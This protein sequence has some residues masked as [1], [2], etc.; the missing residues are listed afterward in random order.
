MTTR[1]AI[2]LAGLALALAI[3]SPASALAKAGGTS[4]SVKATVSGS[5]RVNLRTGALAGDFAGV[6]T[7]I[8]KYTAHSDGTA[9]L[10][11]AFFGRGTT[12]IVAANGDRL[13][14]TFTATT[15]E[16]P[17]GHTA[18][19]VITVKGGTGRFAHAAGILTVTITSRSFSVVGD[20]VIRNDDVGTV[21]GAVSY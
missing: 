19:L 15:A 10:S 5:A 21:T 2:A 20:W 14:G 1:K 6:S 8:G 11:P 4:R 9:V 18:T 16:T 13:T 12:T 3:L 7:H 17:A